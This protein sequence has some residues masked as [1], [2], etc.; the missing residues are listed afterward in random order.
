MT[1]MECPLELNIGHAHCAYGFYYIQDTE[2]LLCAVTFMEWPYTLLLLLLFYPSSLFLILTRY[3]EEAGVS[4]NKCLLARAR[5]LRFG[6]SYSLVDR[7]LGR[8]RVLSVSIFIEHYSNIVNHYMQH[9]IIL[10]TISPNKEGCCVWPPV[11]KV[12]PTMITMRTQ[13]TDPIITYSA[14]K[15]G[16]QLLL[17]LT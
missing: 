8:C 14:S 15:L 11:F 1:S 3:G 13:Y 17:S 16:L 2:R 12:F 6:T 9:R 10:S 4:V 5:Y 7:V